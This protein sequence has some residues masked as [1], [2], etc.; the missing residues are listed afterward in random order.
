MRPQSTTP[1]EEWRPA[2]GFEGIY[3]VSDRGRVRRV[4]PAAGTR[5]GHILKQTRD[6]DG[7]LRLSL[8]RDS[9]RIT[10]KVHRLVAEAFLGPCPDGYEGNH[11]NGIKTDNRPDNLEWV[12]HFGNAC[13]AVTL[14]LHP[15]GERHRA[16]KLKE[17]DVLIIRAAM[18][19]VKV[20]QLAQQ[21]GVARRTIYNVQGRKNWRHI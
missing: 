10:R 13:H 7:Y 20:R 19:K 8:R 3:A 6:T 15:W 4:A 14:G 9:Q 21:F 16:A 18:G 11:R 2:V 12:T 5:V 1:P 17:A